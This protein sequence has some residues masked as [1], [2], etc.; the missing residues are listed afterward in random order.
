[1]KIAIGCDPN[2]ENEK[3]ALK[4][5]I[6]EKGFGEITD[7]GSDDAIYA[8]TAIAVAE[9]VAAGKYDR[10]IL[11]CGTG[12]GMSI[13]AN[14]VKGAYAALAT[15]VYSAQRAR[16]SNDAN[17]LCMGAF[18]SGAKVRELITEAFLTNE[19]VPGCSSQPKVDA[20]VEYDSNR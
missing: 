2:A 14:K 9:A 11:L 15:D 16:L 12:L 18:T 19:F 4:K 5:Y 3:Q 1:M 6:E 10:G 13:A 8:H 17:I 7:F 20:Y